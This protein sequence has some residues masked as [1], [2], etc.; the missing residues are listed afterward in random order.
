MLFIEKMPKPSI[1]CN[2]HPV[3]LYLFN[4]LEGILVSFIR[5]SLFNTDVKFTWF[6]YVHLGR[7][8]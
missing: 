3:I 4:I 8:S 6:N 1:D 2:S 5:K 7:N